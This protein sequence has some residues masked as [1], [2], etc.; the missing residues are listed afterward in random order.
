MPLANKGGLSCTHG[1]LFWTL[2]IVTVPA[3]IQNT[4]DG[5]INYS[6]HLDH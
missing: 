1:V 2:L 5:Q 4:A 3:Q 6:S